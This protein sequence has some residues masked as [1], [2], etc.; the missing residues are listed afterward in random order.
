MGVRTLKMFDEMLG[1]NKCDD[2]YHRN[3]RLGPFLLY[4][5]VARRRTG[6]PPR[7]RWREPV[8]MTWYYNAVDP[9]KDATEAHPNRCLKARARAH[10]TNG[11]RGLMRVTYEAGPPLPSNQS[12]ALAGKFG[13]VTHRRFVLYGTPYEP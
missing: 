1:C 10:G 3:T 5:P 6:G 7:A 2:V 11:K 12:L 8:K 4:E 9:G 13:R